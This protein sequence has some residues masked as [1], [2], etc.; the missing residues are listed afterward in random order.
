MRAK[1]YK[2]PLLFKIFLSFVFTVLCIL[3][4][5]KAM[6]SCCYEPVVQYS[7]GCCW[8]YHVTDI[9]SCAPYRYNSQGVSEIEEYEW[10][11]P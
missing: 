11:D 7:N 8:P 10:V 9:Y 2:F 5:N 4:A 3:I 1:E 6:A